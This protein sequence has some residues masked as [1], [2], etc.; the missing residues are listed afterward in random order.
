VPEVVSTATASDGKPEAL[1]VLLDWLEYQRYS[2]AA[3][4]INKAGFISL[5]LSS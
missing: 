3:A 4:P 5:L 2:S 1:L